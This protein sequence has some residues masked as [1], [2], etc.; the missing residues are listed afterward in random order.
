VLSGHVP[1]FV[2]AL[3]PSPPWILDVWP[4]RA[5]PGRFR[6]DARAKLLNSNEQRFIA[7]NKPFKLIGTFRIAQFTGDIAASVLSVVSIPSLPAAAFLY[8]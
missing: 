7:L 8:F 2:L 5:A 3:V 4:V 6:S 1:G